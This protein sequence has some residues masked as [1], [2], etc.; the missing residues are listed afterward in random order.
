VATQI[1]SAQAG[2]DIVDCAIDSMSGLTSQP[3]MGAI[4]N[5]LAGTKLD[6]GINPRH[7]L[8]LSNYWCVFAACSLLLV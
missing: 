1:A 7:M 2:A 4:V 8:L 5:S 6:T 3:S